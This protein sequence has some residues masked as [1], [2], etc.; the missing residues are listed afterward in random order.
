MIYFSKNAV[1][2]WENHDFLFPLP[3]MSSNQNTHEL[4]IFL[5][6]SF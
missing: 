4:S 5:K 3:L 2:F 6:T 1:L